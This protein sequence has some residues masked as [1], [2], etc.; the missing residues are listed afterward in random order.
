MSTIHLLD[1]I[2]VARIAAGEVIDRPCSVIKELLENSLDAGATRV[3]IEIE[4]G[5]KKRLRITDNGCGMSKDDIVMAPVEHATSKI[6]AIED[7]D[8]IT[9]YGFRGE[10]LSSIAHVAKLTITSSIDGE[11]GY[12][13]T[14]VNNIISPP[15]PASHPKGTTID[16]CDLFYD[17]PVRQRFLKR[18]STEA[19]HV[20][21]A[22]LHSALIHPH[23]DFIL[24]NNGTEMLNTSG[25]TDQSTLL[26][27]VFGSALK[28]KLIEVDT[29]IGDYHFKGHISSPDLTFSNRQKQITAINQR[30]IKSG[31][32]SKAIQ[33]SFRDV[34][35]SKRHP[36][37]VLNVNISDRSQVDVNIHPQ[38]QD[39]KFLNPGFM[40][41]AFPKAIKVSF[42]ASHDQLNPIIDSIPPLTDSAYPQKIKAFQP[43]T[44][45]YSSD[46][47]HQN[48]A[49]LPQN[50]AAHTPPSRSI[51]IHANSLFQVDPDPFLQFD[52]D[53][54]VGTPADI[55]YF[56]VFDTYIVMKSSD[57][58]WMI[59]QHAVHE[60]I[61]YEKIK[62]QFGN[63]QHRQPLLIAEVVEL[64]RDLFQVY[65]DNT[66]HFE[67]LNFDCEEFGEHQ[68]I[69]REIPVAFADVPSIGDWVRGIITRLKEIP[70]SSTDL[71]LEQKERLQ[72]MACKA[73][74]KAGKRLSNL[75]I[76]QLIQDFQA[77]PQNFTCPHG[78]PLYVSF[79]KSDLEKL[80]LRT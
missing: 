12:S 58:V 5:G 26:V 10:A 48:P 21:D 13:V 64:S 52:D 44:A 77:S 4:D 16:V 50:P 20:Y 55:P 42:Q 80:F 62:D 18:D 59:D 43:L 37:V 78:R 31:I 69:I 8:D 79:S 34:I 56:Q 17:L 63:T 73:A 3:K 24:I 36:L 40:F 72:M 75:E 7:L 32:I 76:K 47:R 38:K 9:S 30:V 53:T 28:S 1:S 6:S 46:T 23:K 22:I 51:D 14:A 68:L 49:P 57:G 65:M 33:T 27:H 54:S 67:H 66:A 60:R 70:D 39:V 25:I 35:P 11:T 45:S 71:A 74:I 61:L 2:T 19:A 15:K 29:H 41:D